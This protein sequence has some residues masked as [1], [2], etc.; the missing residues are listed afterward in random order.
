[1]RPAIDQDP[2]RA[3]ARRERTAAAR[4]R[5]AGGRPAGAR[6]GGARR[7]RLGAAGRG[8]PRSRAGTTA[9]EGAMRAA[10]A[11]RASRMTRVGARV[12]FEV[13][14]ALRASWGFSVVGAMVYL[15]GRGWFPDLRMPG[16]DWGRA[17]AA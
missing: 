5:G 3:A 10:K 16:A 6:A 8:D 14:R 9:H 7:A 15:L 17:A 13:H 12:A 2:Q 1:R 4:G 11:A